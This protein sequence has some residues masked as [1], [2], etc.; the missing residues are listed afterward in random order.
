[1]GFVDERVSEGILERAERTVG[2]RNSYNVLGLSRHT[3]WN[4][5]VELATPLDRLWRPCIVALNCPRESLQRSDRS[6]IRPVDHVCGRVELPVEHVE[7]G[8]VVFI[9]AGIEITGPVVNERGGIRGE[10][11]LYDRILCAATHALGK[12]HG[13]AEGQ[14]ADF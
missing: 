2:H 7:S 4:V 9:V 6:V 8:G 12:S 5:E 14:C 3:D 11:C 13:N 10:V 1:C